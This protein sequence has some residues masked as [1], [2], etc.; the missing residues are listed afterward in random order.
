[1]TNR[2]SALKEL[3]K[4]G[5]LSTQ[6][7]LRK[8][9]EKLHFPVTQST[10]SRDLRRIGAIR[11]IDA[12]GRVVYRLPDQESLPTSVDIAKNMVKSI[13][14]A[15][16]IVVIHTAPGTASLVARYLDMHR[17]AGSIGTIAGDDT[18]FLAITKKSVDREVLEELRDS[19]ESLG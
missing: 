4:S 14:P 3:L 13:Q 1:M 2:L 15:S 6:D 16:S 11:V 10:I 7:E 17:P 5:S 12:E 19:L 8:K 9:L 18:V